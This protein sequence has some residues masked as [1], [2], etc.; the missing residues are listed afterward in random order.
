MNPSA[1]LKAIV[2]GSPAA[3]VKKREGDVEAVDRKIEK[4]A[5]HVADLQKAFDDGDGDAAAIVAAS[6]A[7][8]PLR[9]ERAVLVSALE[10]ARQIVREA[11]VEEERR[12]EAARHAKLLAE[13]EAAGKDL[14][15]AL[16]RVCAP[17]ERFEAIS[18]RLDDSRP[19]LGIEDYADEASRI[20]CRDAKPNLIKPG[21]EYTR[22]LS[23]ML[24]VP[25]GKQN[26]KGE[27]K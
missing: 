12:Q 7:V 22:S 8:V 20:A 25:V 14:L 24:T 4:S 5:A 3:R 1:V 10:S 17:L 15:D 16:V 26:S 23:F 2:A 18:D 27:T 13:A 19:K 11:G 6:S 21:G 9:A